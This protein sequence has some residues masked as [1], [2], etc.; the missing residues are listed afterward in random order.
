MTN[1]FTEELAAAGAGHNS[2]V[3]PA[4]LIGDQIEAALLQFSERAAALVK[5]ATDRTIIDN[6]GVGRAADTQSM[7]RTL[8]DT[9]W[10]RAK[11]IADPHN[12]SVAVVKTR[13][14]RFVATLAQADEALTVKVRQFRD[15]QRQRAA[16]QQAEQRRV[17]A[18]LRGPEVVSPQI[19]SAPIALPKARGDYGSTVSDR[20][21]VTYTYPDPRKLPRAV[22]DQPAVEKAIQT[23]LRAYMKMHP[24]TKGVT[25]ST[26]MTTTHRRPI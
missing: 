14:E 17:E 1:A 25:A 9:I 24:K 11:E 19:D 8:S 23:A 21:V 13:T 5:S 10:A 12:R 16:E 15:L 20:A 7:I 26:D 2:G 6:D 18:A 3:D 22:L 4:E